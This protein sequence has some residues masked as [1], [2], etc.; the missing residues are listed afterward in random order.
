MVVRGRPIAIGRVALQAHRA[1]VRAERQA[2][3]IVAVGARHAGLV[4]PALEEGAVLVDLV[5]DLAIDEVERLFE[6]GDAVALADR[7]TMDVFGA[8]L[9]SARVAARADLDLARPGPGTAATAIAGARVD[10]PRHVTAIVER[11]DEPLATVGA[12]LR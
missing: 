12:R 10:V 2:V 9:A 7:P 6:Q 4:H 5:L 1:A 3:R 8:E 11:D